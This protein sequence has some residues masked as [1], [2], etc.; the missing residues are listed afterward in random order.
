MQKGGRGTFK[1]VE[2][3]GELMHEWIKDAK[4]KL[5]PRAP[6]ID[7]RQITRFYKVDADGPFSPFLEHTLSVLRQ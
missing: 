3:A 6:D 2:E 5:F 4:K 7:F 1:S